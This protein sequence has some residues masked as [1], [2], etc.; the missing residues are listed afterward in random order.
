MA[1]DIF[2][3]DLS[4]ELHAV[5]HACGCQAR[6][7]GGVKGAVVV[8]DTSGEDHSQMGAAGQKGA[9]GI[10]QQI[11]SLLGANA[12]KAA[13]D[14]GI[15]GQAQLRTQGGA[16]G[17]RVEHLGVNAVHHHGGRHLQIRLRAGRGRDHLV[18]RAD[19]PA[20]EWLVVAL[21]GRSE[22]QAQ[23]APQNV[24][25]DQTKHHFRIAPRVPNAPAVTAQKRQPP[26]GH[27]RQ[28]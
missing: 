22:Q 26:Q 9:G 11:N 8:R 19:Q 7:L 12:A 5:S 2:P 10:D 27:M 16:V 13:Q 28:I 24:A 23:L 21:R 18:H 3:R 20:G 15:L 1:H 14:H 6:Q 17:R 4:Q 25:Q